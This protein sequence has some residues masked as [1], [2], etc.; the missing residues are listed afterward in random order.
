MKPENAIVERGWRVADLEAEKRKQKTTETR[1]NDHITIQHPVAEFVIA[2]V[3]LA[4]ILCRT[5][6]ITKLVKPQNG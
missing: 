1:K 3:V 5:I 2:V 4:A 6:T